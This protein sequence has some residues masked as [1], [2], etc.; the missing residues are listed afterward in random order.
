MSRNT[1][2]KADL[3]CHSHYSDGKHAPAELLARARENGL[4]H[5]AIT[6][7]DCVAGFA[8][9]SGDAN[10][11]LIPGVEISCAWG[12]RELH[13][14]G[15]GIDAGD[16]GLIA[17]LERQQASRRDRIGAIA[18]RLSALGIDG[19]MDYLDTLPCHALTRTHA[20]D[21]LVDGGHCRNQQKAFKQYLGSRGRAHVPGTWCALAEA[22]QVIKA[23][24]GIAVLAHPGRYPLS[25]HQLEGLVREFRELGGEAMETS[26]GNID[27][28]VQRRMRE[29]AEAAGL[30]Q[31]QG[32]DFH[33]ASAHWTDI[34]RFPAQPPDIKNAIWHHPGWHF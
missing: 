8:E 29:L 30:Y 1:P 20:A 27:P 3:H 26:Y 14:V 18:E 19:L 34:G 17:L 33:S 13:V 28:L 9:I 7:H 2:V 31:S 23:G 5:L 11:R 22:V 12:S 10:L 4:T 21:F 15:L 24:G 32:S 16:S 25:K 6:D